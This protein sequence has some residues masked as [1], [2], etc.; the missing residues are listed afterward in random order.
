MQPVSSVLLDIS[1]EL[2]K[3]QAGYQSAS[4]SLRETEAQLKSANE[5]IH[6][7]GVYLSRKKLYREFLH[8]KN[9]GA[10]RAAHKKEIDEYEGSST[11]LK[12]SMER[13]ASLP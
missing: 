11:Y 8:A 4:C 13:V 5:A 6:H 1:I 3:A 10:F 2:S 12:R 7:L 9:K